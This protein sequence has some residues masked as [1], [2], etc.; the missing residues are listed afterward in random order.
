[1]INK[2]NASELVTLESIN[3]EAWDSF[4]KNLYKSEW[5]QKLPH[6]ILDNLFQTI[7]ER[8]KKFLLIKNKNTLSGISVTNIEKKISRAVTFLGIQRI[9]FSEPDSIKLIQSKFFL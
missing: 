2:T 9:N 1:M 5:P 4:L 6:P 7:S 8:P 3:T